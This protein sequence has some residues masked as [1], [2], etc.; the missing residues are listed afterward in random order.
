MGLNLL[1]SAKLIVD[2]RTGMHLWGWPIWQCGRDLNGRDGYIAIASERSCVFTALYLLAYGQL[3]RKPYGVQESSPT[4]RGPSLN[5]C[6]Q[7]DVTQ[8]NPQCT[9]A[10]RFSKYD[11][12]FMFVVANEIDHLDKEGFAAYPCIKALTRDIHRYQREKGYRKVPLIYSN[13]DRAV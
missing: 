8:V 1:T 2:Q 3:A 12:T 7:A 5:C 9:L 4:E 6:L 11:N 13:K 10:F